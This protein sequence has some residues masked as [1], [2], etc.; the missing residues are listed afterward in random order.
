[1]VVNDRQ[2]TIGNVLTIIAIIVL[3]NYLIMFGMIIV[4][5][6]LGYESECNWI[7]CKFTKGEGSALTH[8]TKNGEPINCSYVEDAIEKNFNYSLDKQGE[9]DGSEN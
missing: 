9:E 5:G 3:I 4:G 2:I 1:M 8:C 7:Y 6:K